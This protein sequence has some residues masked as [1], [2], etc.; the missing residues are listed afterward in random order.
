MPEAPEVTYIT[1]QMHNAIHG[2]ILHDVEILKG[3]YITHGP[4]A[5]YKDFHKALPL[6]CESVK[7][8]GKVIF[9]TFEKNWTII[10]KLG[11][12][13]WLYTTN[14]PKWKPD[15]KN[16]L[17]YFGHNHTAESSPG[18]DT[19]TF[20]DVRSYGTLTFTQNNELITK[21]H[22]KLGLDI[23]NPVT[24]WPVFWDKVNIIISKKSV[25]GETIE[26]LITDQKRLVCGIGNYLKAE[27]FYKAR[28]APMRKVATLSKKEWETLFKAMKSKTKQM[29]KALHREHHHKGSYM[30]AMNVYRRE[31]DPYGNEVKTYKTSTGRTTHWVPA[32]QA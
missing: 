7:N 24:T 4:P 15:F 12:T 11:L 20:T 9:I 25:N 22:E 8:K 31:K 30:K 6:R 2:R 10:V 5:H 29:Y 23:M 1:H 26:N 13:G 3:R 27:V 19:M 21:E 32:I 18:P 28:I 14:M 17:F 16:V